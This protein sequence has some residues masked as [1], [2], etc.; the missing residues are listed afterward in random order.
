[1][2]DATW[3]SRAH[4]HPAARLRLY[5]VPYAGG[6]DGMF[7]TWWQEL[8]GDVEVCAVRL[9]GRDERRREPLVSRSTLLVQALADALGPAAAQPYALYGH[10]MGA[11]VAFE[12][13]RELRRRGHP[14]PTLLAVS[15]RRAPHLPER[16]PLH[17]LPTDLLV[18]R[19]RALG[20]LPD[21]VLAEPE[22]MAM[23]LPIL[24]ADLAVNEIDAYRPD[25]PLTCPIVA[26]GGE[27]DDRCRRDELCAW[28][29]HTRGAFA[30]EI[31]PGGHF[32]VNTA[33]RDLL[34]ALSRALEQTTA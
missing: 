34:A 7:R 24:R 15:G 31:Y 14:E 20:G 12:L 27:R 23:F 5:C 9:P 17:A 30:F 11:R 3:I 18:T 2:S 13:A 19:L 29:D 4:P 21:V 22:L 26:F 33:R 32:F 1:M 28:R 8:P 16:D 10:S 25:E 6:N